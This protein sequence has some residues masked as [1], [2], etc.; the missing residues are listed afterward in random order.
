MAKFHVRFTAILKKCE[1]SFRAVLALLLILSTILNITFAWLQ[2]KKKNTLKTGDYITVSADGLSIATSDG[3][4][5]KEINIKDFCEEL[6][7]CTSPDGKNIYFPLSDDRQTFRLA[8]ANDANSKYIYIEFSITSDKDTDVWISNESYIWGRAADAIRMSI[9]LDDGTAPII[10]DSSEIKIDKTL[11]EMPDYNSPNKTSVPNLNVGTTGEVEMN[12]KKNQESYSLSRFFY[13]ANEDNVDA[14]GKVTNITADKQIM[15]LNST[16]PQK[17]VMIVW[18]EGEDVDCKNTCEKGCPQ[19]E[20]ECNVYDQGDLQINLKFTA[21]IKDPRMIKFS[22]ATY[23][24][25]NLFWAEKMEAQGKQPIYRNSSYEKLHDRRVFLRDKSTGT[26]Y[27]MERTVMNET[28]SGIT[29]PIYRWTV[30]VPGTVDNVEFVRLNHRL[31]VRAGE[32][33]QEDEWELWD[34]GLLKGRNSTTY[35]RYYA[36]SA[37]YKKGEASNL[38]FWST[39]TNII[40]VYLRDYTN[41]EKCDTTVRFSAQYGY[42]GAKDKLYSMPMEYVTTLASG[43]HIYAARIPYTAVNDFVFVQNGYTHTP[44]EVRG[45]SENLFSTNTSSWTSNSNFPAN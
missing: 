41:P 31:G 39:V 7:E 18:L 21:G 29:K 10:L 33:G 12:G 24:S 36:T 43:A 2:N 38:G 44:E 6:T 3:V 34:A 25:W 27:A 4:E 9:V 5:T 23:E 30:I 35:W 37:H 17:V 26:L 15:H 28:L 14:D 45:S 20:C 13:T 1:N 16:E 42:Y 22:D 19:G 32:S 11:S 40:T 8:N